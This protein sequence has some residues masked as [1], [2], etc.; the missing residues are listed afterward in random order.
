MEDAPA[1][2]RIRLRQIC[3]HCSIS[4]GKSAYYEH[5]RECSS[6]IL[7]DDSSDSQ[8]SFDIP[9]SDLES[10]TVGM[11]PVKIFM[12]NFDKLNHELNLPSTYY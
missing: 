7:S 12:H 10:S 5:I 6:R 9:S 1:R 3:P 8:K 2:K 11:N 4:L